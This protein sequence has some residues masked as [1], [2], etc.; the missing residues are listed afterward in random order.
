MKKKIL[1]MVIG[2]MMT[3]SLVACGSS[4]STS[5]QNNETKPAETASEST[6]STKPEE[7]KKEEEKKEDSISFSGLTVVDNENCSIILNDIEEDNLW[8]YT[9]NATVEN[10]SDKT[11]MFSVESAAI[12]GVDNDPLFASEVAAG[13]KANESISFS[14]L[15]DY[16]ISEYT[17]IEMTFRVY[18]SN[19]W[20]ADAVAKETVHVYP[21]GEDKASKFVREAGSNDNTLVDKENI[22][23]IVTDIVEDP[24]WGYTLNM[25]LENNTDS[26]LMFSVDEASI[27]GYMAD[28][29]WAKSVAPGKCA[30]T[31]MSWSDTTLEENGITSV[32]E[33]E[34]LLRVYDDENWTGSDVINE[35]FTINP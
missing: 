20:S 6:E 21:Y 19:D 29:F 22:K 24:I 26:S 3:L 28:P 8:G 31:S 16:G 15:S 10:K 34:F 18:D 4:S 27:N 5:S 14:N 23:V 11:L 17:D 32:E 7:E 12:N 1:V 2:I 13:K 30:F 9:I 35:V 33:I 25:Y